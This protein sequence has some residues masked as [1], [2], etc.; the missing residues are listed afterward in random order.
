MKLH[1][2]QVKGR[3]QLFAMHGGDC[4][5]YLS[6]SAIVWLLKAAVVKLVKQPVTPKV[7]KTAAQN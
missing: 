1:P 2:R 5:M 7:V 6:I 4:Q 3:M